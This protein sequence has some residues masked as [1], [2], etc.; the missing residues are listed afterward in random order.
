LGMGLA[1][2]LYARFSP[3]GISFFFFALF[4]G[5]AMGITAF[6]VLARIIQERGLAGTKL[7]S[8]ALACA[9]ANDVTAWCILAVLIS[10]FKARS[11]G[12]AVFTVG[13]VIVFISLMLL[14]IRP[15]INKCSGLLAKPGPGNWVMMALV[16]GVLTLSACTTEYLGIH[17]LFGSFMAGLIMPKGNGFLKQMI[18]KIQVISL[19]FLLPLFFVYTGLHTQI[20]LLNHG[21]LWKAFGFILLV[22]VAGKFGGSSLS[23]RLTG[24]PWRV[25]LSIGVLM[26]TRGLM[27]LIVLNIGYDLGVLSA[28]IFAM[29][30]LMA[31]VTTCMT[32]PAL[33]LLNRV[34]P[35]QGIEPQ[36]QD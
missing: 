32:G 18:E 13:L 15:L 21:Y 35:G 25:S 4:L 12:Q 3:P 24:L 31:L 30:L 17:A 7:G 19:L 2:F 11:L 22:A 8:M 26:N 34:L 29:M 36:E 16:L 9:A 23:A 20:T 1:W 28:Q 6:P 14:I 10:V 27:E 33:N 5:I